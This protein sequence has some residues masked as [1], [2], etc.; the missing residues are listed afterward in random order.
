MQ[1]A[2]GL[3]GSSD[4]LASVDKSDAVFPLVKKEA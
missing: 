1:L 2:K 4:E 3:L